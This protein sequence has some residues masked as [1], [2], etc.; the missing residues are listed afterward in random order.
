MLSGSL[1]VVILGHDRNVWSGSGQPIPDWMFAIGWAIG[2]VATG[3]WA[4]SKNRR[5]VVNLC[6]VFGAIHF[7]TQ[8]FER[9]GASPTSMLVGG[10]V[11]LGIA[12]TLVHYKKSFSPVGAEGAALR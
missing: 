9:L 10:L 4:A 6:A 7:Y 1:D 3:V 5:W 12:I 8:Y 11:A 2:L